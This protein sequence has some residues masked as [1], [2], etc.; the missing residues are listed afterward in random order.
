[1]LSDD[2]LAR[3]RCEG[4]TRRLKPRQPLFHE[5]DS[6][7]IVHNLTRGS[8][9][10]YKLLPDGRRQVTGFLF[11][12]DFLG[13]AAGDEHGFTAEALEDC[14]LCRFPRMRFDLFLREHP[15]MEHELLR[16]A[17]HELAAAQAQMLLLGRKTAAERVASF[18]FSLYRR[19]RG[20]DPAAD[21]FR[22]TMYRSDI[23][24]YLGLTKET[25]SRSLT[26]FK[27][28]RLIRFLPGD[29]VRIVDAPA[30]ARIATGLEPPAR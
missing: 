18:L 27:A 29:E 24:D 9:K 14:E 23:A 7:D 26:A 17:A 1:M 15:E 5:G 6:A 13:I 3:F 2:A 21:S 10:L 11:A 8:M 25:V 16:M 30:L 19:C 28:R 12:G 22:L 4:T 20:A